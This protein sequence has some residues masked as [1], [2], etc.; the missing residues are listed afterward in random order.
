MY[1]S[2]FIPKRMKLTHRLSYSIG[3]PRAQTYCIHN[4]WKPSLCQEVPGGTAGGPLS[5][6]QQACWGGCGQQHRRW[7]ICTRWQLEVKLRCCGLS[8]FDFVLLYCLFAS[9]GS[10]V[11]INKLSSLPNI[12]INNTYRP[13]PVFSLT[14][15]LY[16]VSCLGYY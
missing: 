2:P 16:C 13:F 8:T 10:H 14:V 6:L 11:G 9:Q 15:L 12:R 3:R 4:G 7:M 1:C 5:G